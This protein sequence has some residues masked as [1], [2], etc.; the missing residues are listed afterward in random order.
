MFPNKR[1]K[2]SELEKSRD[3][4]ISVLNSLD[5]FSDEYKKKLKHVQKLSDLVAHEA[6]EK[7]N[8]NTVLSVGGTVASV[9]MIISHEK[10]SVLTSKAMH[11]LPKLIR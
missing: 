8:I 4:A 3:D 6:P 7:L 2:R 9:I 10:A 1:D 5:P 11:F